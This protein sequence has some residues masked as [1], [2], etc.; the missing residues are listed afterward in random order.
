MDR[1]DWQQMIHVKKEFLKSA[2][3]YWALHPGISNVFTTV[4]TSAH[5]RY[6]RLLS[7]GMSESGL[8]EFCPRVEQKVRAVI[9]AMNDEMQDRDAVDVLKWW[10][11]MTFDTLTDLTFGEPVGALQHGEVRQRNLFFFFSTR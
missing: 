10:H 6:R 2:E 8:K 3:F 7:A 1:N 5:R 4:D 11:M 9:S